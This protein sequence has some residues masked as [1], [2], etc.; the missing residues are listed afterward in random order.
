MMDRLAAGRNRPVRPPSSLA[1]IMN[2]ALQPL[3]EEHTTLLTHIEDIR[4]MADVAAEI[5]PPLLRQGL[6]DACRFLRGQL[7]PHMRAEERGLYPRVGRLLGA[8]GATDP[9]RMDHGAVQRYAEDLGVL[10]DR[11]LMGPLRKEE[12]KT[13]R[14][15]LYGLHA[16]V[17]LHFT[18]EDALYFSLLEERLSP[19]EV[20]DMFRDMDIPN[21]G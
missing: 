12:L 2:H 21:G 14:R 8:S 1:G 7:V 5:S 19:A 18:K 9:M 20:T 4:A 15:I 11:A 3:R 13:L 6:D 10:K 17:T 16:L